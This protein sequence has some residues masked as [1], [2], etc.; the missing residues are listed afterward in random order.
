MWDSETC[1]GL[2]QKLALVPATRQAQETNLLSANQLGFSGN[3]EADSDG[4]GLLRCHPVAAAL[5]LLFFIFLGF[6]DDIIFF[7]NR[8]R[9]GGGLLSTIEDEPD[10]LVEVELE[11]SLLRGASAPRATGLGLRGASPTE[12]MMWTSLSS[13]LSFS[14]GLRGTS[15][16]PAVPL[17]APA[18]GAA[19]RSGTGAITSSTRPVSMST[20]RVLLG[21][22]GE[23]A[24][25]PLRFFRAFPSAVAV[26]AAG[27]PS[28]R[29][30]LERR[31]AR[32][33]S[34]QR[35]LRRQQA[36]QLSFQLPHNV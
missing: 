30:S 36:P 2:L 21:D 25:R 12:D 10:E 18:E 24:S 8:G 32:S 16:G 15:S 3:L 5:E 13:S 6:G 22:G 23:S 7:G 26:A 29:F 4:S 28:C 1:P 35:P 31:A 19:E 17:P 20:T 34:P 33:P 9:R 14:F 11:S 27:R